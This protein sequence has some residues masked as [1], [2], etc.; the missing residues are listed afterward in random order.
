M[1]QASQ[2][3]YRARL[4][5]KYEPKITLKPISELSKPKMV[6]KEL[7]A[8]NSAP[9]S[10][11]SVQAKPKSLP[12]L[13]KKSVSNKCVTDDFKEITPWVKRL[14]PAD[15]AFYNPFGDEKVVLGLYES[16]GSRTLVDEVCDVVNLM[17]KGV[18]LY[19]SHLKELD[20]RKKRVGAEKCV[21]MASLVPSGSA[22]PTRQQLIAA[23]PVPTIVKPKIVNNFSFLCSSSNNNNN[24]RITPILPKLA[25]ESRIEAS[26]SMI[27]GS[28]SSS[29]GNKTFVK[30]ITVNH[31]EKSANGSGGGESIRIASKLLT[32]PSNVNS[33]S[34]LGGAS[35]SGNGNAIRITQIKASPDYLNAY[36]NFAAARGNSPIGYSPATAII[37]NGVK[38]SSGIAQ[39][40]P[41]QTFKGVNPPLIRP[42]TILKILPKSQAS[43]V[44]KVM[45]IEKE[46]LVNGDVEKKEKDAGVVE[47]VKV[48]SPIVVEEVKKDKDND[49]DVILCQDDTMSA[50]ANRKRK[51]KQ[52]FSE[53][54]RKCIS[55][56]NQMK[57][58][59]NVNKIV[60]MPSSDSS[61]ASNDSNVNNGNSAAVS[62]NPPQRVIF[63]A[64][65]LKKINV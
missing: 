22:R 45:P 16:M 27:G 30:V 3:V 9:K 44:V 51:R 47:I 41:V 28:S 31:G 13:L 42:K 65:Q 23:V 36:Q 24:K 61:V 14:R 38:L 46:L 43:D 50:I 58:F 2:R 40:T 55:N 18:C 19:E 56:Q 60:V 17:V 54:L 39:L 1:N 48:V 32:K 29:S 35:C 57:D 26:N 7:V 34:M 6:K 52:D 15:D 8:I 49:D 62:S 33:S 21:T 63:N 25:N 37:R 11:E 5:L 64:N 59:H 53:V 4:R 20:E 10:D 12:R